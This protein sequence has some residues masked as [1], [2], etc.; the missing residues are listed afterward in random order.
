MLYK[1]LR[2]NK[3]MDFLRFNLYFELLLSY[4]EN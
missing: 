3:A 4:F 1:G 2:K